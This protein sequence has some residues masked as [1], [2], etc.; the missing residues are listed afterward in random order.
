ML[1]IELINADNLAQFNIDNIL[2]SNFSKIFTK[3]QK[4]ILNNDSC[5][6]LLI[7]N[8]QKITELNWQ[9]RNKNS[10]TNILSFPAFSAKELLNTSKM[11]EI[12]LGDLAISHEKIISESQAQN[13]DQTAHFMHLL[14]L[15]ELGCIKI[16][17]LLT[18]KSVDDIKEL[19]NK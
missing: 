2:L 12:Y 7:C 15:Q 16:A 8:N 1:K 3:Q 14:P 17:T 4:K 5:L 9:Y 13:K 11:E 18:D 6:S 10:A 19:F